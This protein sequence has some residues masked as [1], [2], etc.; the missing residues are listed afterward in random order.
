[1][2]AGGSVALDAGNA[3]ADILWSTGA[4]SSAISVEAAGDYAVLVSLANGCSDSDTVSVNILPVSATTIDA[5]ACAGGFYD[6]NGIPIAAGQSQQF[7]LQNTFG[8]DSV[9]TVQ[10]AANPLPVVDLGQD[11][12]I[13]VGQTLT[14]DAGNAGLNFNW[15]NGAAT[16]TITVDSSDLYSVTV[17]NAFG[18]SASND[19]AV[20]VVI[21]TGTHEPAFETVSVFPNPTS[22]L[23]TI[24]FAEL[25]A[26]TT[27]FTVFNTLGQ[28]V[29]AQQQVQDI[30]TSID[31]GQL[32]KGLYLLRLQSGVSVSTVNIIVQ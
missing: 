26:Q 23:V 27:H 5:S 13:C 25:P 18:C 31:L 4:D 12:T 17:T 32:P 19:V 28:H 9:V 3:G 16:Q 29:L 2:C 15:S 30:T 20:S 1:M 21:C 24:R 8:C 14:L 10:V 22:G 11:S 7:I 6:Y